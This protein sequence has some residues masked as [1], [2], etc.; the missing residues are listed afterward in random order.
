MLV[1][2]LRWSGLFVHVL[3]LCVG[4]RLTLGQ[5]T[6][7]TTLSTAVAGSVCTLEVNQTQCSSGKASD[8]TSSSNCDQGEW[9][10]DVQATSGTTVQFGSDDGYQPNLVSNTTENGNTTFKY[11]VSCCYDVMR[12]DDSDV[13]TCKINVT[14]RSTFAGSVGFPE[15][16]LAHVA[17]GC[18]GGIVVMLCLVFALNAVCNSDQK[19][20]AKYKAAQDAE[21]QQRKVEQ[22]PP[23]SQ[24]TPRRPALDAVFD[25]GQ[26]QGQRPGYNDRA[27]PDPPPPGSH[28]GY[29]DRPMGDPR[30][31]SQGDRGDRAMADPR[32]QSYGHDRPPYDDRRGHDNYDDDRR[33]HDRPPYDNPRGQGR[34]P[35]DDP[36]GHD[37]YDDDGYDNWS[38]QHDDYERPRHQS[39]FAPPPREHQRQQQMRRHTEAPPSGPQRYDNHGEAARNFNGPYDRHGRYSEMP[40]YDRGMRGGP[41]TDF[42][43]Y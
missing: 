33:G 28:G 6:A 24:D 17:I 1:T 8:G 42:D 16:T 7:A 13:A 15:D 35:Y 21:S 10:L 30:S 38:F 4:L 41:P 11:S 26:R 20:Q 37:N 34:P 27:L 18:G 5:T 22:P 36:R 9:I 23:L 39:Q 43:M 2:M 40:Q 19:N 12:A 14:E 31:A 29:P 25:T 3:C 32:E